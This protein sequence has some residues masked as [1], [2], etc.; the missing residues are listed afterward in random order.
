MIL[1]EGW[2]IKDIT[3]PFNYIISSDIMLTVTAHAVVNFAKSAKNK[4]NRRTVNTPA[5]PKLAIAEKQ[6]CYHS[7]RFSK[8]YQKTLRFILIR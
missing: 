1:I 7:F 6:K 8:G 3:A 4:V 2:F 5:T